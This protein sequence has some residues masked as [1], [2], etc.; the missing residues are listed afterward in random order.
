MNDS[1][2]GVSYYVNFTMQAKKKR[3]PADK[4]MKNYYQLSLNSQ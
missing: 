4:K 1:G 3:D 2:E